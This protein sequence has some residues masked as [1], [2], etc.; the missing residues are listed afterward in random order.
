MK[1]MINF[2]IEGFKN[3][4]SHGIK[5]WII[6]MIKLFIIF[7]ILKVF[8][9]RDFLDTKF[10]NNTDKSNYVIEQLTKQ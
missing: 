5:L 4:Q 9:F 7:F 6:I 3:L 2:Y 8:F 1:R 10:D